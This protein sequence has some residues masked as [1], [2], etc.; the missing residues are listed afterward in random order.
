M[1][2]NDESWIK[3]IDQIVFPLFP[4]ILALVVAVP[5]YVVLYSKVFAFALST[6][7]FSV[8]IL[9]SKAELERIDAFY[10]K[11]FKETIHYDNE[12]FWITCK[13]DKRNNNPQVEQ[14][15]ITVSMGC[16]AHAFKNSILETKRI[17]LPQ[18]LTANQLYNKE[19][20]PYVKR[21]R[22]GDTPWQKSRT[23]KRPAE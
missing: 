5:I 2:K 21:V 19:F 6:L 12:W 15:V 16:D 9:R 20:L 17:S 11:C 8:A 14:V 22:Q 4:I 7:L 1:K 18:G 10:A 13:L 23:P 3:V